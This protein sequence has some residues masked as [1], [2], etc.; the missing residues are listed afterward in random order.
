[1]ARGSGDNT[2]IRP[3]LLVSAIAEGPT[4]LAFLLVPNIPVWILFGLPL[5]NP[6]AMLIARIGGGAL[7]AVGVACWRTAEDAES[8]AA[9]GLVLALLIY[10]L[11]VLA[12]FAY[13]RFLLGLS[14]I[15]LWVALIAH[16]ILAL[17]CIACLRQSRIDAG[18]APR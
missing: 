18:G 14:G 3:L 17:W 8:R 16:L 12:L 11:I 6:L 1:M 15:G 5:D 13:A 2:M 9:T 4:G 7:I 10:D